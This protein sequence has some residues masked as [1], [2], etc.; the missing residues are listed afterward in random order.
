MR[1]AAISAAERVAPVLVTWRGTLLAVTLGT[2]GGWAASALH[3]PLPW[4]IGSM[5]VTTA[6][7][8]F[9]LPVTVPPVL[10]A[11]M[12][13]VLG[14][15][16]GSGFSPE[17]VGR[18]GE[19]AISLAVLGVYTA[20]AGGAAWL[21]FRVVC[22]YDPVTAYF[23]GMPGG[24]SVMILV[25]TEMGGDPRLISLSQSSRLLLVVM[26]LPFALQAF[27]GYQPANRPPVGL[28]L[29][30]LAPGALAVL[31]AC[32]AAGYLGAR[33]LKIPAAA[34]VGPMILSAAVH[35]VGWTA[36]KPPFEVVAAAQVVVGAAIG[37]RFA[38]V[39]LA[40]MVRAGVGAAGATAILLAST[41]GFAFA[42]GSALDLPPIALVLAYSPGGLAEMSLIAVAL[43]TDAAFVAT[44]HIVRI[45]LVVVFA[46][47][48]YRLI[49]RPR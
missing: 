44:H 10:R 17:M 29:A 47:L 6:A 35:L 7:A 18:M 38:G 11:V 48:A 40:T 14:V 39:D 4:M 1:I 23:A 45:F 28:P 22:R 32:A 20:F 43:G 26:F 21:Y 19:W 30:E 15:M 33:A 24:L 41:V 42:L 5:T 16:L 12:V 9:G 2:A 8:A 34:I 49:R 25:G 27:A 36:A 31:A 3:L 37:G 46:P 13:A